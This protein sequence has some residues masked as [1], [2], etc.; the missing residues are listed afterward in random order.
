L[1]L[2]TFVMRI[3]NATTTTRDLRSALRRA[4]AFCRAVMPDIGARVG[5]NSERAP[6]TQRIS[7]RI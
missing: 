4:P 6:A 3:V 2:L 1:Q 7:E 5:R